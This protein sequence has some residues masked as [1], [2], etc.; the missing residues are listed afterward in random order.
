[1]ARTTPSYKGLKPASKKARKAAQGSSKK[2]D[3]KPEIIL[4]RAI[5]GAGLRYR[6]NVKDLPGKPDV[7]FRKAK[8]AV[9]VDGDFWHGRDWPSR[10]RSLLKGTNPEYWI[11]KI[12]RNISKGK[13][14]VS[15]LEEQGWT[16][17]RFWESDIRSDLT[18]VCKRILDTVGDSAN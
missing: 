9:F 4:R 8:V 2:A 13:A 10:K 5:W 18:S 14:V 7:V 11:A 12:E 17:L 15:A 6:K 3:T 1:M 16:V